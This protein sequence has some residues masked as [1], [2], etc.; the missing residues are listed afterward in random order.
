[1]KRILLSLFAV[2]LVSAATYSTT[3]ALFLDTETSTGN[4]FAAGSMDLSVD[5]NNGT[6]TV[7]F[8]ITDKL[9]GGTPNTWVY[10]LNNTGSLAGYLDVENM[11]VISHENTLLEPEIEAG[12]D[13]ATGELAGLVNLLIWHDANKNAVPDETGADIIYDGVASG[14]PTNYELNKKVEAGENT[15]IGVKMSWPSSAD[16]NR[17]MTDDLV[18]GMTFEL[19]QSTSQ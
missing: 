16:D 9:P 8:T 5:G 14:L 1:M 19:G 13:A 18:L 17:G 11:S 6:N 4:T 7:L 12:D 15:K 3:R 2:S 10:T